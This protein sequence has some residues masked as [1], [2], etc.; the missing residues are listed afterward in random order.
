MTKSELAKLCIPIGVVFVIAGLAIL[1]LGYLN[2]RQDEKV[3]SSF[4]MGFFIIFL[5]VFFNTYARKLKMQD[6]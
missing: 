4:F 2:Y 3:S 6:K 5:G 1:V